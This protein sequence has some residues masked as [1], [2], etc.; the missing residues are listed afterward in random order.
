MYNKT[1]KEVKLTIVKDYCTFGVS[2]AELQDR[3]K[4][5]FRMETRT[6]GH[7]NTLSVIYIYIYIYI[8]KERETEREREREITYLLVGRTFFISF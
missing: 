4:R 1:E 8:Y 5:G 7:K 2:I 6:Q 3:Y